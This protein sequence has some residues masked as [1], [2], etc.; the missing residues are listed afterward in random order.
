LVL[1]TVQK[2][3]AIGPDGRIYVRSTSNAEASRDRL[4]VLDPAGGAWL[5]TAP[6]DTGTAVLIG[7]RG[8]AWQVPKAAL[9]AG[10]SRE[11]RQSKSFALQSFS[12]D[13]LSLADLRGQVAL[14][15][16]W[17]SWCGP[18]R[19]ELPL[20]DSLHQALARP[21]FM[22]IG[23]NEDLNE[24]DGRAFAAQLGL[25]IPSLLGRGN[26][27][28]RFHYS[29]LPYSVLIDR[30]GRI[31]REY[32]GFGG[33][34]AFDDD[35]AAAV[36][37]ELGTLRQVHAADGG[38]RHTH[39]VDSLPGDAETG[40]RLPDE[41]HAHS[42]A[43]SQ[44]VTGNEIEE[45]ARHLARLRDVEP[46]SADEVPA[47]HWQAVRSALALIDGDVDGLMARHSGSYELIRLMSL[48]TQLHVDSE[49]LPDL[50]KT[51]FTQAWS[52]HLNSLRHLLE[53]YN[54]LSANP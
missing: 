20:L 42:H 5:R 48:K 52:D 50:D 13:T 35:V 18:C 9:L 30:Q 53:A 26:M 38:H 23:I 22:V 40:T 37:Q 51:D 14:V 28:Q 32:Y 11:R 33:R 43:P 7:S 45:L 2:A 31:V 41:A 6:L 3:L 15:A 36:L 47:D 21:D 1:A 39:V 34:D 27:R 4:D 12:G 54:A 44:P 49:R 46:G 25:R 16:F 10:R 19:E 29:G 17:A 24:A 8:S